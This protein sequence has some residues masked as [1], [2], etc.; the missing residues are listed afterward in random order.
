[1]LDVGLLRTED[2]V[3]GELLWQRRGL[4]KLLMIAQGDQSQQ[5]YP[6]H[7]SYF[8]NK[9]KQPQP[10]LSPDTKTFFFYSLNI[11]PPRR[12][13][14]SY[15]VSLQLLSLRRLSILLDFSP[16]GYALIIN[17]LVVVCPPTHPPLVTAIDTTSIPYPHSYLAA[18]PSGRLSST[19]LPCARTTPR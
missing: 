7:T 13:R 10:H 8:Q 9:H 18:L 17:L 15:I 1:M 19:R 4:Y 14:R 16:R 2:D 6:G 3:G 12:I 11:I 5:Q